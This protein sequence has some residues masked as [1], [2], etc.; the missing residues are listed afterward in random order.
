MAGGFFTIG[1]RE[2]SSIHIPNLSNTAL[3]N[4][5]NAIL[6]IKELNPNADISNEEKKI[7]CIVYKL[8]GLTYDEVKIV[9]PKTPI[10]KE[11]YDN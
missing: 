6:A 11:T 10:T 7:D 4:Y 9:D 5:V 3:E 2:V 1:T 8:Y